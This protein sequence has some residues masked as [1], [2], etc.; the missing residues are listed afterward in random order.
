MELAN[1]GER[2]Q[3]HVGAFPATRDATA[4]PHEPAPITA[5]LAI[6]ITIVTGTNRRLQKVDDTPAAA[7]LVPVKA[8]GAAKLRL[9]AA[10]GANERVALA[11]AMAEVVVAAAAPLPV[12]VVCDDEDVATWAEAAGAGII[13]A[14][15]TDLNGAV[16]KGFSDLSTAGF[17]MV[18]VAHGDLPHARR[19]DRVIEGTLSPRITLVP[20]RADDGTNVIALPAATTGFT[21]AYGPASFSRHMAEAERHGHSPRVLRLP[22][23]QWDVD[24]PQD[25]PQTVTN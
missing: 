1:S 21:F 14:P 8:F 18:I 12:F 4:V 11:R 7:V 5:T 24:C 15:G 22:D 20:D 16:Q 17:E 13:W 9:Q 23:L 25:L 19:L 2:A 10:L 3:S 6:P